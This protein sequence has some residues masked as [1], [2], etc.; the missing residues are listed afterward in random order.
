MGYLVTDSIVII[1]DDLCNYH[2]NDY[3]R[4]WIKVKIG[5]D[6]VNI[7]VVY[8]PVEGS[9]IELVDEFIINYWP[10]LFQFRINV[11]I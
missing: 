1:D 2:S 9:N 6:V 7:A 10:T 3:E 5:K 11:M 8:F 4:L